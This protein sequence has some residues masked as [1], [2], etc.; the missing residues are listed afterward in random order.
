MPSLPV[1]P[2]PRPI[3]VILVIDRLRVV[4]AVFQ[5]PDVGFQV[6]GHVDLRLLDVLELA[7]GTAGR[8]VVD[9]PTG[10]VQDLVA[11]ELS[12]AGGLAVLRML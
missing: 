7:A 11:V 8:G 3:V 10:L 5:V 2:L 1:V 12:R 6:R 9:L 4:G